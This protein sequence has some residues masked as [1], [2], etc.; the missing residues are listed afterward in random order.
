MSL[1]RCL[2][3]LRTKQIC[4]VLGSQWG[5]EGKGKLVDVLAK[6]Y[7]IISRFNGGA[8]AGHTL[9]VGN[10]KF[11]FHLLPCGMLYDDK[12]SVLGNG[13]VLAL[14][15]LFSE[16]ADVEKYNITW[17]NKLVI[18]SRA[19]L[20]FRNQL[21]LDGFSEKKKFLGTTQ[22]GIGPC[23]GAKVTRFGLRVGDLLNWESFVDKYNNYMDLHDSVYPELQ[24]DRKDE[25]NEL[26]PLRDTL[27]EAGIIQDTISLINESLQQG[28]RILAEGANALMLDVD[29]GTYP[30]VTSS[31][32]SAGG[33]CTGMGVSPNKIETVVGVVKAYTTR[34]GEGP[35]PSLIP[36]DLEL[37][38]RTIGGEFGA[39][40]GRPRKCGWLDLQLL[41]YGHWLNNYSS[42]NLTKLD[43][44]SNLGDL[45]VVV[46]YELDGKRVSGMPSQIDEMF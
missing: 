41:K 19:H 11:A 45:Q 4:T 37:Q 42:W 26:K 24:V 9:K 2:T 16:I 21:L 33:I 27:V 22:K 12:L 35:F 46:G 18:S 36:G 32:T 10:M 31:S 30:Y 20:T 14:P 40:T 5:D 7:D 6:D 25:L 34:V 38:L 3:G 43:C 1:S 29:Y 13:V 8:N 39:T 15:Q 17:K 28:K 44:L 23:Y